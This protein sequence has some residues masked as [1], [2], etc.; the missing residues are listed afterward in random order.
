MKESLPNDKLNQLINFNQFQQFIKTHQ[1][2]LFPIHQ[3]Q[4][5]LQKKILGKRFWEYHSYQRGQLTPG[6]GNKIPIGKINEYIKTVY[7]YDVNALFVK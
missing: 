2:M 4:S 6:Y 5:K 1:A 7:I 3:I